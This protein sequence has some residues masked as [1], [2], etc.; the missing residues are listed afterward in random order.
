M[1]GNSDSGGPW[2]EDGAEGANSDSGGPW[3]EDGAEGAN[4][5]SEATGVVGLVRADEKGG[6]G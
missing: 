6:S 3:D 1:G 5:G 2:D 4:G